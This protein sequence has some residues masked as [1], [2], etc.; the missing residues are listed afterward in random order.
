MGRQEGTKPAPLMDD[1]QRAHAPPKFATP[2]P[3]HHLGLSL[4]L[5]P[6]RTP[7]YQ[8]EFQDPKME[9]R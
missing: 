5:K 8:W 3:N 2:N 9:V 4:H 6:I 7:M 1:Y